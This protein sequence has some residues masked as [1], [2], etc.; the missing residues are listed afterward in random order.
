MK[1]SQRMALIFL[2][3]INRGT[4]SL[5]IF[6][7]FKELY[8]MILGKV[9]SKTLPVKSSLKAIITNPFTMCIYGLKMTKKLIHTICTS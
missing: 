9:M 1:P 8:W 2:T 4:I 7:T 3:G 6:Y 5:I